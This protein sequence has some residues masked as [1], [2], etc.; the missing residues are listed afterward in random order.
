MGRGKSVIKR[1]G[2]GSPSLFLRRFKMNKIVLL[3]LSLACVCFAQTAGVSVIEGDILHTI[4]TPW[5]IAESE[6][7]AD[8]QT[9]ALSDTEKTFQRV[10]ALIAADAANEAHISIFFIPPKWN[11]MR[12][13][14]L[15][16]TNNDDVDHEIYIGTLGGLGVNRDCDLEHVGLLEWIIDQQES[17]YTQIAFTSGGVMEPRKGDIVTGN[18]SGETATVISISALTSG[19]WADGDAAGTITYRSDSGAFTNSETISIKARDET[20]SQNVLTH[21]ASDLVPFLYADTVVVTERTWTKTARTWDVCSPADAAELAEVRLDVVG[22]D[23]MVV[24]T[25]TADSDCKLL[26]T[27]Y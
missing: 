4:Q 12:F 10:V 19:A 5:V 17:M 6:N 25:V 27:G 18:T 24:V 7:S 2:F 23:V 8:T 1:V 14:P 20:G 16:L 22:A 26:V 3:F 11:T 13:R 21:A 15:A 9:N